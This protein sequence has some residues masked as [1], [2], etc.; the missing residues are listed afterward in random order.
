MFGMHTYTSV[1]KSLSRNQALSECVR[2][3]LGELYKAHNQTE[4]QA[5]YNGINQWRQLGGI[6]A[7]QIWIDE[8]TDVAVHV[9]LPSYNDYKDDLSGKNT[10]TRS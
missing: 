5:V 2:R 9:Q 4:L 7:S 6:W 1:N 3:D 10:L 8:T